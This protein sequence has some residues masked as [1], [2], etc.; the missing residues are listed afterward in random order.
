MNDM[1]TASKMEPLQS[2]GGHLA[3]TRWG[4]QLLM[5]AANATGAMCPPTANSTN[6]CKCTDNQRKAAIATLVTTIGP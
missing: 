3:D 4:N 1:P 5:A 2:T 6:K